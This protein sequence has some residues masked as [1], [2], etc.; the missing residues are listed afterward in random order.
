MWF[1]SSQASWKLSFCR[2]RRPPPR[3]A[4]RVPRLTFEQLESRLTPSLSTLATFGAPDGYFLTSGVIMD[5]SGDLYGTANGGGAFNDGTVFEVAPGSDKLTTLASFNGT[6]G[7]DPNGALVMDSAGNLY[8][9][10]AGG[11][12]GDGTVFELAHGSGT[13]TT[14]A[15]FNGTDGAGAGL[16]TSLIVDSSGNLYGTAYEGGASGDGTVFE[17]AHGSGAITALASFN[18]T[19]GQYP[20]GGLI[21]DNSGN[22]YGTAFQGGASG[23][24]TVFEL[25][26]G[27]GTITTL[28]SFNGTNGAN[29]ITGLI[30]DSS[31]NLYGTAN[32]GG[33]PS[34]Y[35]TVF[36]L[37]QGSGTIT[38]LASFNGTN[39]A[40]PC[41][42]VSMDNSGNLYGATSTGGASYEGTVFELAQGSGTITTL[43]S[44]NGVNGQN[45][46][47]GVIRDSSGN[48]YGTTLNQGGGPNGYG[49]VFELAQGSGTITTLASCVNNGDDPSS[50]VMDSAGNLYGTTNSGGASYD[51]T[52][53]ELAQGSG[54]ITT[55]ASFNGINGANPSGSVI[56]DSSGNLYGT[57]DGGGAFG[58]GT[59]F[60]LP[61][62]SGTIVTLASFNGTDG[63]TPDC[64]LIMDSSGNVYGTTSWG[65]ASGDGTV[66]E[67]AQG[68]G[69]ITT[70][71]SFNGSD[72]ANPKST[73]STDSSGNLYGATTNGGAYGVGTV[74]ELVHS[75]GTITTLA[76]FYDGANPNGGVIIDRSGNLYGTTISGGDSDFGTVFELAQGSGTITTLA[77]FNGTNGQNPY[78]GVIRDSSGNLYGTADTGDGPSSYGTVFELALGSRTITTLASFSVT[79]GTYPNAAL[80]MDRS[81]DL[82]GTTTEGGSGGGT[83]FELPLGV[84]S[85]PSFQISGF[86][87]TATAGTASTF[88]VTVQNP[89][90]TADTG[91]TGTVHFTSTDPQAGLPADYTFTAADAGVHT[92]T[93]TLKTA[94]TQAINATDTAHS[95]NPGGITTNVTAA[96]ASHL[97]ITGPS[98]AQPGV[99]FSLRVFAFDA[100][101]NL[102]T[103]YTGTV[104]FQS[105]DKTANLPANYTFTASDNGTHSF[106]GIVLKKKGKQ[107]ITATDV[108][109]SKITGSLSVNVS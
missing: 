25:A 52:V 7:Y 70:L 51:G 6:N 88:T 47:G 72:G 46:D 73:L 67:L 48:L 26:Q 1:R 95:V 39:G 106:S 82:Y 5:S 24:G 99:A 55:L 44:F 49:T 60:E 79:T 61:A 65:G 68:S 21:G 20:E 22:L 94:G 34:S 76:S 98:T 104:K 66:F 23:D 93:A 92:F 35:G 14:L 57:T 105:S 109:S 96:A 28:A 87:A 91:Y 10:A 3:P 86:P 2:R 89:D 80:L 69:T 101:G 107:S 37:A 19:D 4:R 43:A 31:G 103:G 40:S 15:S 29:P 78:G 83:V 30:R 59:V 64:G 16:W 18:G 27:S 97:V 74:F 17:L 81:G 12:F 36:E 42:A 56:S 38:T 100:Y 90:G 32:T 8:G 63:Q 85:H 41:G 45:L 33:G 13:I 54:T 108:H 77:S 71:A 58:D 84:A 75:S 9:T 102:A 53:F 11:A 62:G 50:L